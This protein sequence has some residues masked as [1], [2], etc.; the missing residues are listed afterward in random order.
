MFACYRSSRAEGLKVGLL[1]PNIP[2]EINAINPTLWIIQR[3]MPVLF[4]QNPG[5]WDFDEYSA[6]L[7]ILQGELTNV[8]FEFF[9]LYVT[10]IKSFLKKMVGAFTTWT[11]I[12]V[13]KSLLENFCHKDFDEEIKSCYRCLDHILL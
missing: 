8:D 10:A 11:V 3:Y 6:N 2:T 13:D 4:V 7:R 1:R 12:N 9:Y 5:I